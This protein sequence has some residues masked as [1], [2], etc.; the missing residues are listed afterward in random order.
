MD[1]IK[2]LSFEILEKHKSK[3]GKNFDE[4][5]KILDTISIIRSKGLKNEIAGYI[6]KFIKREIREENAKQARMKEDTVKSSDE[7][8]NMDIEPSE[9]EGIEVLDSNET[10]ELT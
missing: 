2:R 7:S 9:T 6:T 8:N 10:S 1:R 3:F 5:K 4:N